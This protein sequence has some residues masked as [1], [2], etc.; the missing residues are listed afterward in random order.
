[1]K[2]YYAPG[3]CSLGIHAIIRE[4]GAPCE[5][6]RV[7]LRAGEQASPAFRG[8]NPKG[9]VPVLVRDEDGTLTEF[10]AIAW[11]L[12]RTH[13]DA[14]LIPEGPDGEARTLELV[15][16][17]VATLHMRGFTLTRMPGKF[18]ADPAARSELS[19]AGETILREGLAFLE[20]CLGDRVW[21]L[22]RLSI[23]DFAALYLLRWTAEV[24]L[25]IPPRLA[26]LLGRL[27]ARPSVQAALAEEGIR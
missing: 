21:L 11:W 12:A 16:Y 6:V 2:L 18:V 24:G 5:T 23:A 26:G 14:G 3:A 17:I 7:D 20:E 22:G 8:V 15:D 9:K 4:V 1:M 19:A 27:L 10:P 25:D 13:P